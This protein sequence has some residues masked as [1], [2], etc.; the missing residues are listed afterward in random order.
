[1]AEVLERLERLGYLDDAAFARAW[2]ESRDRARPRGEV[3]LRRELARMGIDDDVVRDALAER[4]GQAAARSPDGADGPAGV[5]G[6]PTA[7]RLAARRLLETRGAAIAREPD[8]RRRRARAY[9]L[10]A[11][12]GFD[13]G[14]C[15]A[16]SARIAR[17]SA[18]D[19]PDGDADW[20]DGG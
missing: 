1:V 9:A 16:E 19:E 5:P 2:I 8:P 10:L 14:I 17:G 18:G 6:E 13:P 4:E 15:A 3:A 12:N 20:L 7:D 11:R